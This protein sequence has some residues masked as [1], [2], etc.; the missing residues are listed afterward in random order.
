MAG[1][2]A[3][4]ARAWEGR[5]APLDENVGEDYRYDQGRGQVL[6]GGCEEA[7]AWKVHSVL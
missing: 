4:Q 5:Q 7:D 3:R 6:A 2:K 1:Q